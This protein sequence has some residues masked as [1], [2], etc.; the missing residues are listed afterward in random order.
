VTDKEITEL[1]EKLIE[2]D[3]RMLDLQERV[4]GLLESLDRGPESGR[5]EDVTELKQQVG[6]LQS[7]LI[8]LYLRLGHPNPYD[9]RR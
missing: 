4:V 9:T 6:T 2:H 5:A 7:H 1:F 8:N 3:R